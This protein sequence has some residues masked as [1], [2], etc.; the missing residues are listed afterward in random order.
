MPSFLASIT[1][2]FNPKLFPTEAALKLK[3]GAQVMFVKNDPRRRFVN[4]TIGKI[5][6]RP[7][8]CSDISAEKVNSL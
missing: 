8:L 3:K 4:G 5:V 1:G 6:K 7:S 2:S